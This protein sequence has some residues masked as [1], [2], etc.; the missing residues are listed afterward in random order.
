MEKNLTKLCEKVTQD[1]TNSKS[2]DLTEQLHQEKLPDNHHYYFQMPNGK[3]E[4]GNTFCLELLHWCKDG[5]KIKVLEE[6]LD[7]R[8]L[9]GM[10]RNCETFMKKSVSLSTE[11]AKLKKL[12]MVSNNWVKAFYAYEKKSGL[13]QFCYK[14]TAHRFGVRR[15]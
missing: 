3:Y 14:K 9:Q 2:E 13:S 11:K 7:Y 8:D 6:V 5:D 12:L 15:W 4:V 1:V 10:K